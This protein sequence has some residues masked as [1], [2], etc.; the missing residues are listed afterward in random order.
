M[1]AQLLTETINKKTG[2]EIHNKW[3]FVN[4]EVLESA[5]RELELNPADVK[6][7]INLGEKGL[8]EDFLVSFSS[9][10]VSNLKVKHTLVNVVSKIAN[11]GRIIIVGRGSAAIL[12]GRRHS[13]HIRLQAPL[14]YRIRCISESLNISPEEAKKMTE[15]IDKKR[16]ALYELIL[17]KKLD[18]HIFDAA[19]NCSM[20]SKEDIVHGILALM[21][22][23]EML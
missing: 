8:M 9:A 19:F 20:L 22:S 3:K 13:L 2:G 7:L 10:Y 14:A 21:E 17:G 12:Q 4:K 16:V 11:T 15:N 1:I 5:A 18:P 23:K 6:Y